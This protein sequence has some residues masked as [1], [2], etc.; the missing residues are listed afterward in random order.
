MKAV[1]GLCI[2]PRKRRTRRNSARRRKNDPGSLLWRVFIQR[3]LVCYQLKGWGLL[4]HNPLLVSPFLSSICLLLLL[5]LN[6]FLHLHMWIIFHYPRP[7]RHMVRP[8]NSGISLTHIT[9]FKIRP[10]VFILVLITCIIYNSLHLFSSYLSPS[11]CSCI[12]TLSPEGSL[13]FHLSPLIHF[14]LHS[15]LPDAACS[16]PNKLAVIL[17][18]S[19]L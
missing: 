14:P 4:Q 10:N 5:L 9:L 15:F 12:E 16:K 8:L 2:F 17:F 11:P 13:K 6:L 19:L 1:I 3:P 7:Y 18:Q